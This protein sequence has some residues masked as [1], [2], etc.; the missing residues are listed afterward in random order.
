MNQIKSFWLCEDPRITAD[1]W[2]DTSHPAMLYED[3][4]QANE[5]TMRPIQFQVAWCYVTAAG[6]AAN[7]DKFRQFLAD[8][9]VTD[10]RI[11]GVIE[12]VLGGCD[13]S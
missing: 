1:A 11:A 6:I 4:A 3:W 9:V 5:S 10:E 7:P 13:A 2:L 8:E 12:S